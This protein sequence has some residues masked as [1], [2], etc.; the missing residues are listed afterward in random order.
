M[1]TG[2]NL[3]IQEI[4]KSLSKQSLIYGVSTALQ[5][6]GGFILLPLYSQYFEKSEYGTY[7][8]ILIIST[9][10][11]TIF[12]FGINSAFARSYFDYEEKEE[13][14]KV[15]NTALCILLIGLVIQVNLGLLS[16]GIISEYI[17][18]NIDYKYLLSVSVITTALTFL[19]TGIL[20]NL[21]V[22]EFA[23]KYSLLS[24]CGFLINVLATLLLF[25]FYSKGIDS[26]IYASLIA[27]AFTSFLL[28]LINYNEI[29]L[30]N[31]NKDEIKILLKFGF[32]SI[33]ASLAIMIG[34]WGDRFLIDHFLTR[35]ELGLY[36]MA[37]RVALIYNVL[38]SM[39]FCLVWNPLMLKL[40]FHKNIKH[41]FYTVTYFYCSVS[42]IFIFLSSI[43]LEYFYR[44]LMFDEK[45]CDSLELIPFILISIFITSLQNIYSAGLFYE[46]KLSYLFYIYFVVG[47]LNFIFSYYIVQNIGLWGIVFSFILFKLLSSITIYLV[48][49]KIFSFKIFSFE[50]LRVLIVIFILSLIYVYLNFDDSQVF[51]FWIY[52]FISIII[53]SLTVIGLNRLKYLIPAISFFFTNS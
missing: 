10:F 39:P 38:I 25:K 22:K 36:S 14:I 45:F 20:N 15:F 47:I 3:K 11:S 42:V 32:P 6:L 16:A 2:N 48:S 51:L 7:S 9:I 34:E 43:L 17:L 4:L 31:I 40:R 41:I 28:I 24:L 13:R 50:Y 35:D 19:N 5:P 30:F 8:L 37:F 27:N 12:H 53:L 49:S 1:N 52:L 23:W 44:F 18:K 33:L 29:N 46:R 21:R 26:P